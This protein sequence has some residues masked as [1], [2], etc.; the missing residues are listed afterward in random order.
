MNEEILVYVV[1]LEQPFKNWTGVWKGHQTIDGISG[2]FVENDEGELILVNPNNVTEVDTNLP[3]LRYILR[4]VQ[5]KRLMECDLTKEQSI[6]FMELLYK[7]NI[8]QN[9]MD[10]FEEQ[11]DEDIPF[12]GGMCF[13]DGLCAL[14]SNLG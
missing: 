10:S 1:E 12:D 5:I 11:F 7:I 6:H 13:D 2:Y 14:I 8:P 3:I 4:D 9:V